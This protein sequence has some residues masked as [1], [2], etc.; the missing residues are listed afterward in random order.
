Y[1]A[2]DDDREE[3]ARVGDGREGAPA[4]RHGLQPRGAVVERAGLHDER[5]AGRQG[6]GGL[7]RVHRPARAADRARVGATSSARGPSSPPRRA[8]PYFFKLAAA[9]SKDCCSSR[10][11]LTKLC[12]MLSHDCADARPISSRGLAV[13]ARLPLSSFLWRCASALAPL[14]SCEIWPSRSFILTSK[15][16]MSFLPWATA[17]FFFSYV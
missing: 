3:Q 17:S 10:Y 6:R 12:F 16:L 15:S 5:G 8:W 9:L 4:P 7:P 1:V 2:R 13:S 14:A 11:E